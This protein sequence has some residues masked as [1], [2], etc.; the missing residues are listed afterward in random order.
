[1]FILSACSTAAQ[2]KA[3][4]RAELDKEAATEIRRVCALPN[5]ERAA[6]IK[7]IQDESGMTV[8]CGKDEP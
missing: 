8:D 4:Q 7:K 3:A 1:V 5:P 2:L 6:K